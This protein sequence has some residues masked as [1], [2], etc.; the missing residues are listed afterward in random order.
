VDAKIHAIK[1]HMDGQ[2]NESVEHNN[3]QSHTQTTR[4]KLRR[5]LGGPPGNNQCMQLLQPSVC[6]DEY[7]I[8]DHCR[9]T[10]QRHS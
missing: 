1:M 7:K 5:F 8:P 9:A 6:A 2:T 4:R 3:L 10:G